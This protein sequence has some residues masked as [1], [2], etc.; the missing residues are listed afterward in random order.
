MDL[1]HLLGVTRAASAGDIERAYRRLARRYHPGVNPGDSVAEQMYQ[2]IEQAYGVL[3]D[4]DRRRQYDRVGQAAAVPDE[5]TV[6]FEGFDFSAA[7][8][9][10]VAATFSEL[11]A[12]VFRQAARQA[13]SPSRGVA[14]ETALHLSFEDAVRGGSFPLSVVRQERC[15]ACSGDGR[16]ARDPVVCPMC[17]GRGA[18]RWARG[19]M[20]FTRSCDGCGGGGRLLSQPCRACRGAGVESR[21][22]VVTVTVPPGV[23]SGARI[24]V[25][26]R[27]H[28]GSGGGPTGDLYVTV[29]VADHPHFRRVGR[30]LFLTLP[31]A[32]HEAVLGAKVEVPT[33]DGPVRLRI[34]PGTPSGQRLRLGGRGVRPMPGVAAEAGDLIVEVQIVL[35]P[36]RDER[37]RELLREFGRLND[38]DVRAG[39][40]R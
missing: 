30:D 9:G 8:E 12:D 13:T 28:A 19:H 21:S 4:P 10:P 16:V 5:N 26:G 33:L 27:G 34:P 32:I 6:L 35:P 24:A 38:A 23:E 37:S 17:G 36:I 39:L 11:F 15:G 22:E 20:V 31:V 7:A 25:P 18:N 2:R 29:S 3:G 1:Y 14:L 40:F